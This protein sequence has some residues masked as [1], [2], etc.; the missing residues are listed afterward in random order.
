MDLRSIEPSQR[1]VA[2]TQSLPSCVS[3]LSYSAA[4]YDFR[5]TF[6]APY[7]KNETREGTMFVV[8]E[9]VDAEG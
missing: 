6:Q 4:L 3:C 1:Q 8:V 5:H 9:E 7:V 2:L